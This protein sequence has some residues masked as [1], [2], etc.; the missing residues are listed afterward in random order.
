[1]VVYILKLVVIVKIII[2]SYKY[3]LKNVKGWIVYLV[4]LIFFFIKYDYI[5]YII[6]ICVNY[7]KWL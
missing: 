7:I 3:Y 5:V 2:Y 4:N 1:M 6:I